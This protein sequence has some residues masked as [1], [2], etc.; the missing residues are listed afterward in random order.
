[1]SS[2]AVYIPV[3]I[4]T[5][6]NK[7]IAFV[8]FHA[9][10]QFMLDEYRQKVIRTV[11]SNFDLLS[12]GRRKAIQ[13]L[14]KKSVAIPGFRD[15]SQAPLAVKL[16]GVEK[17]FEKNPEMTGQILM[18]WSELAVELG[19]QVHQLLEARGWEVLPIETDRTK[20]PGFLPD[21][22]KDEDYDS[23]ELAYRERFALA[24]TE[25]FDFRLMVIWVS[26]R[27]PYNTN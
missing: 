23:L 19:K 16:R 22:P 14:I 5:M 1:M 15:A 6:N 17:S 11:L 25:E 18:A 21:W 4:M 12:V 27:L 20:I 10:N 9:I 8:P 2:S 7:Q 26:G 13:G 3:I 24:E